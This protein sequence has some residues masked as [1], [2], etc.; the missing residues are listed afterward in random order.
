MVS[1]SR[2]HREPSME[3]AKKGAGHMAGIGRR[4]GWKARLQVGLPGN[5]LIGCSHLTKI[6]QGLLSGSRLRCP[7]QRDRAIVVHGVE[8]HRPEGP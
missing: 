7:H 5:F 6:P 3:G 4:R 8:P 1:P 2:R